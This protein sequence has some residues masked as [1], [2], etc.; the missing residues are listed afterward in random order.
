MFD[1]LVQWLKTLPGQTAV[2]LLVCFLKKINE[3]K[4]IPSIFKKKPKWAN[5]SRWS[6]TIELIFRTFA[7]K[8]LAIRSKTNDQI[9]NPGVV[10]VLWDNC[11]SVRWVLCEFCVSVVW[12][13]CV[14]IVYECC[15]WVWV[16]CVSVVR[17]CCVW[18]LRV[19]VV[20]EC[21][22][23]V[24]VWVFECT[25]IRVGIKLSSVFWSNWSFFC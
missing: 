4:S 10:S 12:V 23:R 25:M 24:C 22:V 19:T 6:F 15:V 3:S 1:C 2:S 14:S 13:L 20:S 16:L 11:V 21:C 7:N 5:W 17:E 8:K 9:P 18:V